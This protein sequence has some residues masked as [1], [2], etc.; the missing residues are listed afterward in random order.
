MH[1]WQSIEAVD[2]LRFE[3]CVPILQNVYELMSV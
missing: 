1:M 3:R 2:G